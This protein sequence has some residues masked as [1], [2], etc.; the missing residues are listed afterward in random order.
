[1]REAAV[2]G[3]NLRRHP[4]SL[5]NPNSSKALEF[6][7]E[8]AG[9]TGNEDSARDAALTVL[10]PFYDTRGFSALGA[11]GALGCVH[12]LFTI[13]CLRNLCRHLLI[14]LTLN[15]RVAG[16]GQPI[17]VCRYRINDI[18]QNQS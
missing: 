16:L 9:G 3:E 2:I 18:D 13:C 5:D 7:V 10:H 12:D 4:R 8:L 1:M 11:I 6:F 15:V 17:S 14:S